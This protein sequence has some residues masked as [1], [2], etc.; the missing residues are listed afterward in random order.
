[1]RG[2][3]V[4]PIKDPTKL[5]IK[6][7]KTP[8]LPRTPLRMLACAASFSGKSTVVANMILNKRM[9]RGV[10][11]S[12]YIFSQSVHH[13]GTWGEV[14]KYVREEMGKDPEKHFFPEWDVEA[15]QQIIS[16]QKKSSNGTRTRATK[17]R[18]RSSLWWTTSLIDPRSCTK[19]VGLA[20]STRCTPWG[21]II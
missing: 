4:E 16:D 21:D 3:D 11:D 14:K 19:Q 10:W 12:I 13:D 7:S 8:H 2:L 5:E 1:M 18:I 6:Q 20:F 17:H 15:I 9:Y